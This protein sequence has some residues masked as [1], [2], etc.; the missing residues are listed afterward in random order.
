MIDFLASYRSV[1]DHIL[2][3]SLLAMSQ[4]IVLRAGTFS[5]GSAAFAAIGA[6]ATAILTTRNGWPPVVAIGSGVLL[7]G[8]VSAVMAFPLAR[9]RGVFQAVATMALVQVAVTVTLNWEDLTRGA[10]G[11]NG[12]PKAAT[13]GWLLLIVA[14]VVALLHT[15]GR[16]GI[17]RAMDVIREDETVAV[18]LGISV[19]YYQR[20]AMI[21]S[22]LLAGLA[23]GLQACNSYAISPEEFGFSM[24]VTGLAMAVLGGRTSVWGALVG[25]T[26]LTLL[27][28]LFR[29]FAE[30]R[31]VLQGAL[32]MLIIIYL[33]NG[34][35]DTLIGLAQDR[36]VR[37]A[38]AAH[39]QAAAP[40]EA[41]A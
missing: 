27:P 5:V 26:V 39:Q 1:V 18:S 22:G 10:L 12:I 3:F 32:L 20:L 8:I 25:A 30:Y 4:Y 40:E 35:A 28:E 24:L 15:I 29:P 36:R 16:Y 37:R 21:L 11:I 13:T 9:L 7:A 19:S 41:R 33:P 6:Y 34:I 38:V 14:V 31:N 17:G 23:G 2:I